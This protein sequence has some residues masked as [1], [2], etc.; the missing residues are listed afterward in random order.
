MYRDSSLARNATRLETSSGSTYGIGM[1]WKAVNADVASAR[2]GF[3]R[4]GRNAR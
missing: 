1:A 4:S 2:V 3:S